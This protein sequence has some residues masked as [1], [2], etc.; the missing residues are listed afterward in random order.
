MPGR[1]AA[2]RR[3]TVTRAAPATLGTEA[4]AGEAG[5]YRQRVS[6]SSMTNVVPAP[7]T[8]STRTRPS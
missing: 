2:H 1:V 8:L 5:A 4:G 3:L 6:G 7:S